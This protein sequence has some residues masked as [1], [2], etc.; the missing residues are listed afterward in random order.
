MVFQ[1]LRG[2]GFRLQGVSP[3]RAAL[4]DQGFFS[5][6]WGVFVFLGCGGVW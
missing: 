5:R 3:S 4:L 6:I 1:G 2:G